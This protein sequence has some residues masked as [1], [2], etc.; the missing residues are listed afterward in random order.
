MVAKKKN[1]VGRPSEYN[2]KKHPDWAYQLACEG[3]IDREIAAEF[4]ISISTL[5]VWKNKYPELLASIKNGKAQADQEVVKS[6]FKRAC[7]YDITEQKALVVG[8]GPHAHVETVTVTKHIP[9]DTTAGI[10]WLKNRIPSEWRDKVE[11]DLTHSGNI[12]VNLKRASFKKTD[13]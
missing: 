4:E 12:T 6:L 13:E 3:K 11:Q 1:P 9:S 7:G 8:N 2:N 5:T 10:F